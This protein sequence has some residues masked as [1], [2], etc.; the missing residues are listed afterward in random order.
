MLS[1]QD[2]EMAYRLLLG[3]EPE[4]SAVVEDHRR[5]ESLDALR[6]RF[7]QSPEFRS[8]TLLADSD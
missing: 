5:V 6:D 4:S 3:R 8:R 2:V 1:A 7:L